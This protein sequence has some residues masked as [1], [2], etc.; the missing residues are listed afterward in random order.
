MADSF[1]R[2]DGRQRCRSIDDSCIIDESFRVELLSSIYFENVTSQIRAQDT[3]GGLNSKNETGGLRSYIAVVMEGRFNA[4]PARLFFSK[5]SAILM[6]AVAFS[7]LERN[8]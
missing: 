6:V 3:Q 1:Q 7:R 2:K 5:E 8:L 4:Y